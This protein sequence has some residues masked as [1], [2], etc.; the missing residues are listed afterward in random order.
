MGTQTF[1]WSAQATVHGG[2]DPIPEFMKCFVVYCHQQQ[3]I[4]QSLLPGKTKHTVE[5]PVF[6]GK[7]EF[8]KQSF[9]KKIMLTFFLG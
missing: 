6:C 9:A 8:K 1:Y 5:T 3:D 4:G 2:C 7:E